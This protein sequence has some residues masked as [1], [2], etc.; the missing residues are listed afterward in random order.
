M[1][2]QAQ[3]ARYKELT[4]ARWVLQMKQFSPEQLKE[5]GAGLE[6]PD[7]LRRN[8]AMFEQQ[9]AARRQYEVKAAQKLKAE[10]C[11]STS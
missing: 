10:V 8:A 9:T 1:V 3:A 5:M 2:I 4:I 6:N 7:D 11:I